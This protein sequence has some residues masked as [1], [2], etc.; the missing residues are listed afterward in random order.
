MV[1][2]ITCAIC[3]TH[4][5]FHAETH[6]IVLNGD[7]TEECSVWCKWKQRWSVKKC[8]KLSTQHSKRQ[9]HRCILEG[10]R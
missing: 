8:L 1:D 7:I 5:D 10:G 4:F 3:A 6:L 9:M 2:G